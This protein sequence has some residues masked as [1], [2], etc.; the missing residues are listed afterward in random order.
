MFLNKLP[1]KICSKL[2]FKHKTQNRNT[3]GTHI[4]CQMQA[5]VVSEGANADLL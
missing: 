4:L 2:L 3:A 1:L 5:R